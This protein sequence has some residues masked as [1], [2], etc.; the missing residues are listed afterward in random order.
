MEFSEMST[1]IFAIA[2]MVLGLLMCVFL[3]LK[4]REYNTGRYGSNRSEN[5]A[6]GA[7]LCGV[8]GGVPLIALVAFYAVF[9]LVVAG[10]LLVGAAVVVI[11]L[12]KALVSTIKTSIKKSLKEEE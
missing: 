10:L 1:M 11:Y 12:V 7:A 5:Y 4:A 9:R 8:L 3:A 6:I 2:L